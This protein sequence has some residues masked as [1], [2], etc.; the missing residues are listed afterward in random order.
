MA[1]AKRAKPRARPSAESGR[2]PGTKTRL[3]RAGCLPIAPS[4]SKM[5]GHGYNPYPVFEI[6]VEVVGE[7]ERQAFRRIAGPIDGLAV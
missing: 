6:A 4:G 1:A 7:I 3:G 2:K 5:A